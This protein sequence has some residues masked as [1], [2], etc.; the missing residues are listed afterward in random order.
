MRIDLH[1]HDCDDSRIEH[2]E[3]LLRKLLEQRERRPV[4]FHFN[5]TQGAKK[6]VTLPPVNVFST[7]KKP[8]DL[9]PKGPGSDVVDDTIH[10]TVTSS[11]P[12]QVEI[13]V[14]DAEA[15]KYNILTPLDSGTAT[16]TI[17]GNPNIEDAQFEF[18]YSPF[19]QGQWNP[20]FGEAISDAPEAP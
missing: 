15:N 7:Q 11:D 14:V 6:M 16:I 18:S 4:R 20:T 13:E 3:H 19:V 1:L 5:V 9:N 17:A 10:G 8:L 12:S 2:I